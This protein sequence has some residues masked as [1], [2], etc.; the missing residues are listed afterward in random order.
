MANKSTTTITATRQHSSQGNDSNSSN[1]KYFV[2]RTTCGLKLPVYVKK[3]KAHGY[4]TI[5]RRIDG[6]IMV[7][8]GGGGGR[9]P[10]QTEMHASATE[11]HPLV[12][13]VGLEERPRRYTWC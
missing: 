5:V 4:F 11:I 9:T 7:R 10:E 3:S 12:T 8:P 2:N 13:C 1:L 6:D